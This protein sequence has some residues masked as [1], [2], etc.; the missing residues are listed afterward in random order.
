MGGNCE[1]EN[2][3]LTPS[4]LK[5]ANF[6]VRLFILSK[7]N[8]L[9]FFAGSGSFIGFGSASLGFPGLFFLGFLFFLGALFF[10]AFDFGGDDDIFEAN[11]FE[12]SHGRGVS[13]AIAELDNAGITAV[14]IGKLGGDFVEQYLDYIF[15]RDIAEDMPAGGKGA[16]L[17]EGDEVFG[18]GTDVLGLSES[19][20]NTLVLEE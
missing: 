13:G 2:S 20:S 18:F 1:I 17:G 3:K 6:K 5:K 12:D 7:D 10:L 19:S 16:F 9:F 15:L 8:S 14:P 4:L 11:Q